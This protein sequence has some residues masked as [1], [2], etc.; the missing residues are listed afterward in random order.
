VV[1]KEEVQTICNEEIGCKEEVR[2]ICNEEIGKVV[3]KE[4]KGLYSVDGEECI[5]PTLGFNTDRSNWTHTEDPFEPYY[6]PWWSN[7]FNIEE[8]LG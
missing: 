5:L 3:C 6:D 8:Q 7:V 1:C 4:E 2:T